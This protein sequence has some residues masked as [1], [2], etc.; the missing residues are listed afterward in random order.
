MIKKYLLEIISL[1]A[2]QAGELGNSFTNDF[3]SSQHCPIKG[4]IGIFPKNVTF[5]SSH[6]FSAPPEEGG[7]IF[8]SIYFKKN[9]KI[10][11]NFK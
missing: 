10:F 1:Y 4:S 9:N 11:E 2:I 7:N 6:I 8:D 3:P 5:I